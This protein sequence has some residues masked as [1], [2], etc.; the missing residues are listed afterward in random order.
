MPAT[1]SLKGKRAT[2]TVFCSNL[3][4]KG[5][6]VAYLTAYGPSQEVRAFAQLLTS[7]EAELETENT[8]VINT[9]F[10]SNPIMIPKLDNGYTGLY[11]VPPLSS[12][13]VVGNSEDACF[14]IYSRILDQQ[15]FVHC[16][17]YSDIFKL[18]KEVTPEIGVKKCYLTI[19][20]VAHEVQQRI[21]Y[22]GFSFPAS[23]ANLEVETA[24]KKGGGAP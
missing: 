24:E 15:Q 12:Q 22:G 7:G 16:D 13:L 18:A 9:S 19:D 20:N 3:I 1:I 6:N 2:A 21:R 4:M 11:L 8:R 10:L 17:W 14:D 5:R 23:T